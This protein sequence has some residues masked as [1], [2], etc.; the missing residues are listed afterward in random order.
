MIDIDFFK[1]Y[2][3]TN[4]HPQG[5]VVLQKVAEL[6][7]EESRDVDTVFRYGGE[8][9]CIILPE[10]TKE[11]AYELAE[12]LRRVIEEHYFLKEENQPNKDLTV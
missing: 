7:A 6:M 3:D 2:N 8:K 5:D 10:T 1:H 4:G 11:E 9:F 12:R